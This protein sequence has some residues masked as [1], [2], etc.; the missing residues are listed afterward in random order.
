MYKLPKH[1]GVLIDRDLLSSEAFRGLSGLAVQIYMML[2]LNAK[3]V[4]VSSKRARV[5]EWAVQNNGSIRLTYKQIEKS[6]FMKPGSGGRRISSAFDELISRGLV[7]LGIAGS[8]R[9]RSE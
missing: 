4:R 1:G 2:R 3:V 7:D 8:G 9:C 6:L 5:A